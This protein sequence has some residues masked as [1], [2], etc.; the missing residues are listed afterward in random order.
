MHLINYACLQA[1]VNNNTYMAK[2]PCYRKLQSKNIQNLF[3]QAC[4]L[5]ISKLMM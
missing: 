1:L 4:N 2:Q 3:I 5:A